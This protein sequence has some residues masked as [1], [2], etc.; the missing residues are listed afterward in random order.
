MGAYRVSRNLEKSIKDYIATNVATD[1]T[2]ITV[3]MG[4][5]GIEK[6]ELPIITVRINATAHNWIEVGSSSTYREAQILV[7][8]FAKNDGQRLDLKDYL[9]EKLK[10]GLT[11]NEYTISGGVV[12][13]TTANGRIRILEIRDFAISFDTNK[14]TLDEKDKY[15]HLITLTV[16]T[17]KTES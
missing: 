4:W 13:T 16:A 15:R 14:D 10:G 12:T 5:A 6:T 17:S 8:I 2:G 1:W 9:I 7:D 11:Y 3:Q